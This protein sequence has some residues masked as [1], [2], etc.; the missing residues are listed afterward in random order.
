MEW[1]TEIIRFFQNGGFFMY[2]IAAILCL[3]LA[4]TV[5]RL[6]FLQL[7]QSGNKKAQNLLFKQL[8]NND[9]KGALKIASNQKSGI[10]RILAAGINRMSATRHRQ[11]IEYAL[12]ES[13]LDVSLPL[14]NR[15]PYLATFA[16]IATLT[17]LLGTIIGLIAAFAAVASADPTEK[18]TLLSQSISLAMNTTAFGLISAIPLLLAHSYLQS[19]TDGAINELERATVRFMSLLAAKKLLRETTDNISVQS[20]DAVSS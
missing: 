5:E 20:Q 17:G 16:N 12:E 8:K 11:D 10:S 7:A 13:L 2:P 18:A 9:F 19:K 6:I 4:I 15:T 14:E 1:S 3:G